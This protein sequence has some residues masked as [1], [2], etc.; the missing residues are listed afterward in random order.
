[1]ASEIRAGT[2]SVDALDSLRR[3]CD[4]VAV[5]RFVQ[6]VLIAMERGAPLADVLRMQVEDAREARRA[7]LM[8]TAGRREV[9]MLVPVVFILM[10]TVILFALYPALVSLEMVVP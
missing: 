10:P 6:A 9:L 4:L 7:Q 1:M 5:D 2:P 3:R 8:E